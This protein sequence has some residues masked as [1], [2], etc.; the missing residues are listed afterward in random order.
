MSIFKKLF[1]KVKNEQLEQVDSAVEITKNFSAQLFKNETIE[2]STP[3]PYCGFKF[4]D[5]PQ[6]KRKCPDC[7]NTIYIIKNEKGILLMTEDQHREYEIIKTLNMVGFTEKAFGLY[8]HDYFQKFGDSAKYDEFLWSLFNFVLNEKAKIQE[9]NHMG[10]LYNLLANLVKD[11][12]AEYMKIRKL[13]MGM[14]LFEYKKTGLNLLVEIISCSD[15]C[16]SCKILSKKRMS[17]SEA[18]KILPLPHEHCT[19]KMGCRCCYAAS[20]K[21]SGYNWDK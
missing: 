5:I 6:R 19:H 15:S 21:K 20:A 14:E 18:I 16:E 13:S 12:P 8:K 11:Q 10:I 17:L 1:G 4:E 7:K 2:N 3:C 9:F